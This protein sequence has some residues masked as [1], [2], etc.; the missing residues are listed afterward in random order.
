MDAAATAAEV[1]IW[2]QATDRNHAYNVAGTRLSA[3][4]LASIGEANKTHLQSVLPGIALYALLPRQV[5]DAMVARHGIL[6]SDDVNRLRLP[7]SSPLTSLADL[8]THQEKYLLASQRLTRNGQGETPFK[9]FEMYLETLKGF[10]LVLHSMTPYYAANPGIQTQNLGTLFPFLEGMHQFLLKTNPSSPFSGAVVK[11]NSNPRTQRKDNRRMPKPANA[12]P[13]APRGTRMGWGPRGPTALHASS[14]VEAALTP[15]PY[16]SSSAYLARIDAL[17]ARIASMEAHQPYNANFDMP[18]PPSLH[19]NSSLFSE[20]RPRAHYCWLHGWNN[21]HPGVQ[22]QVMTRSDEYT[23]EMRLAS[24]PLGTGGNPKVGVPVSFVRPAQFFPPLPRR[25]FPCLTPTPPIPHPSLA[26]AN[27]ETREDKTGQSMHAAVPDEDPIALS[28]SPASLHKS[29][30]YYASLVRER[31]VVPHTQLRHSLS[32]SEPLVTL[33]A[34]APSHFPIPRK[35]TDKHR[36]DKIRKDIKR[37]DSSKPKPKTK[38]SLNPPTPISRFAHPNPFQVLSYEPFPHDSTHTSLFPSPF[39][40]PLTPE[41]PDPASNPSSDSLSSLSAASLNLTSP[42][43]LIADTGCTGVLLQFSNFS[44]LSPFFTSKPLPI[45]PFT[46]PDRSTLSVGGPN[47]LTGQLTLPH[48]SSPV[49]CY[50]LPDSDLS[51]SLVGISPLLRPNGHAVFTSNS[52]DIFDSPSSLAPFL[53]GIKSSSSDLWFLSVP[54][55]S[56]TPPVSFGSHSANFTLSSLPFARFVSYLHRAFGSPSISTFTRAL[57]RGFIHGI[58]QL[59]ASLVRKFPPLSPH[60]AFGH[61][62]MLRKNLAS[63]RLS[64][65]SSILALP[66]ASPRLSPPP[67]DS[68]IWTRASTWHRLTKPTPRKE[69]AAA[70]LMG[71]FPIPSALNHEYILIVIHMNYIHYV[72]MVSR[73]ASSYVTAFKSACRFFASCLQPLTHLVIDNETSEELSNFFLQSSPPIKVQNVPP[74]NHRANKSER[75]IRTAKN[76]LI[77]ILSS[78][79]VSFPPTQWH[80]LIPIAELTLNHFR[81]FLL[82]SSVSAWHGLHRAPFDFSACPIHP[83]GQLVVVHDSAEKRASWAKH[84]KRAF[85]VGPARTHYRCHTVFVPLTSRIRVSDTL[86]HY[87][88]PLFPFQGPPNG[89]PPP[90]PTSPQVE[91]I[92]LVGERFRDPDLGVC[93]VLG[94]RQAVFLQPNTGNLL[95]GPTL[96]HGWTPTLLY[97]STSGSTEC[98]SVAEIARWVALFVPDPLPPPTAGTAGVPLPPHPLLPPVAIPPLPPGTAGVPLRRSARLSPVRTGP[99]RTG[100][101]RFG[102]DR[103][104]PV[105]SGPVRFGLRQKAPNRFGPSRSGPPVPP[106][107]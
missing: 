18:V 98:S 35:R 8:L 45:V 10:P 64:F 81:H 102:P 32:W 50:F 82:D 101:V 72:P 73:S 42:S 106:K 107:P 75:S 80:L 100:P 33:S 68:S 19:T 65:P 29:E 48:K 86:D 47:H 94:P 52:V 61:L 78:T 59:T 105:Q 11:T 36:Q 71:R 46:L 31:P 57:S 25:C 91:G 24:G 28:A 15:D 49:S 41:P 22:C 104:G 69:W 89:I 83:P 38:P 4:L 3:A 40:L 7:L 14:S 70:D 20:S 67:L 99:V 60:T 37:Q 87:P 103:F 66:R 53:S 58:P 90:D 21:S 16:L 5:I 77:S 74:A 26:M 13:N 84:G 27:N 55:S 63:S 76:H 54:S 96:P 17:T 95:P 6:T 2:R 39:S 56:A 88:D 12:R 9:Y 51:H 79:H 23:N 97:R 34:P 85:Y 92:E 44:A 1:I 93:T 43:P 30:G 62:D